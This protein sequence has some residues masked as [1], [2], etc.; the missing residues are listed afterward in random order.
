MVVSPD[1]Q[2]FEWINKLSGNATVDAIMKFISNDYFI[3]VCIALLILGLWFGARS[4]HQRRRNQWGIVWAAVGVGVSNLFIHILNRVLNFDPFFRP[5]EAGHYCNRIFGYPPA[6]PTFPANSA[7][8]AF[9]F[10][11][12]VFMGN[13]KAG[14]LMF[15]IAALWG[16]SRVYTGI[17]YPLDIFHGAMI[18][19]LL[20]LIFKKAL[21]L[22]EPLPTML[23]GVAK[24][25][26]LSDI[27][28]KFSWGA[29]KWRPTIAT[30][31]W[32]KEK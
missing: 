16:F 9:A 2:L 26:H 21:F 19:I 13:R 27:P 31:W 24:S 20:T 23:L 15:F 14:V 3:V 7:A 32:R 4:L 28:E 29:I 1:W 25:L 6:D 18:G 8:V 10:A 12:G 22:F 17:H 5:E 30:K 11:L